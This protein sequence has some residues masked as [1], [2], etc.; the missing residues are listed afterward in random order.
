M[1]GQF[2]E[3]TVGSKKFRNMSATFYC[4]V[5]LTQFTE[6]DRNEVQVHLSIIEYKLS[7]TTLKDTEWTLKRHSPMY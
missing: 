5:S 1:E 3:L 6:M 4:E 7:H 2:V